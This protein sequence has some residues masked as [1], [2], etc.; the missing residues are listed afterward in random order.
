MKLYDSQY[1]P[2]P[3]RVRMF[4]AEKGIEC[5][6]VELNIVEGENLTEEF[7]KVNPRGLLPTLV[8]DDGSIISE[9]VAI[10]GYLEELHPE[11]N[12]LGRDALARAQIAARQREMEFDGLLSAAEAF[13]NSYPGFAKRGL[14]GNHPDVAAIPDL[15]D[16]G[17]ASLGRFYAMLDNF[18]QDNEFVAGE[19]FTIADITAVCTIEFAGTAARCP[20]PS[21]HANLKRWHDLVGSRASASA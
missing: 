7:L 14:S 15:V 5:E 10:C 18:L 1:A 2:N 13:R 8:L 4:M 11:P 17:K 9:S 20:Y 12:L 21:E 19:S 6:K 16:R 3:R